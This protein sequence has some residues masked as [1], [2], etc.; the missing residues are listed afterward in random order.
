MFWKGAEIG[1]S[2]MTRDVVGSVNPT[3]SRVVGFFTVNRNSVTVYFVC[4]GEALVYCVFHPVCVCVCVF[5]CRSLC[6]HGRWS[7]C[8]I[9]Q[10]RNARGQGEWSSALQE[11]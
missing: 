9:V 3:T 1:L 7:V 10:G 2:E 8:E 11:M 6:G 5:V 4:V